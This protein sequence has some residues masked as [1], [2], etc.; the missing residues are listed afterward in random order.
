M[1]ALNFCAQAADFVQAEFAFC[2][3]FRDLCH[4]AAD[5]LQQRTYF[6]RTYFEMAEQ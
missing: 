4:L 3:S 6:G 1:E 5:V 2:G